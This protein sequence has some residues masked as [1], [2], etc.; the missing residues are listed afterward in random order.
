MQRLHGAPKWYVQEARKSFKHLWLL[1]SG[2]WQLLQ[3]GKETGG[4]ET[5]EHCSASTGLCA[6]AAFYLGGDHQID[7]KYR[8]TL[9]RDLA[10][11]SLIQAEPGNDLR[12][13]ER[14]EAVCRAH[15]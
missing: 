5:V 11:S 14:D 8:L 15:S 13:R 10:P 7:K 1:H 9:S 4:R 12:S 2:L 3:A 6:A